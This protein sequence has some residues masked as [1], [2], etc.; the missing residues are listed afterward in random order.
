MKLDRNMLVALIGTIGSGKTFLAR[1][2]IGDE[3]LI[4]RMGKASLT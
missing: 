1:K 2:I 4:A 3:N